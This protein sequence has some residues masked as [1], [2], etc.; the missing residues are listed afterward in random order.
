MHLCFDQI[1]LRVKKLND[2]EKLKHASKRK[3]STPIAA[4]ENVAAEIVKCKYF[5]YWEVCQR[6]T[7]NFLAFMRVISK[8][9]DHRGSGNEPC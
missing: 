3:G 4:M 7:S 8:N 2:L 1:Y 5:H 9:K 6:C